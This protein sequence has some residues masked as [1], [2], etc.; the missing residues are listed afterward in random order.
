MVASKLVF[1][2]NFT[3]SL[4]LALKSLMGVGVKSMLIGYSRSNYP[5]Y[6][7]VSELALSENAVKKALKFQF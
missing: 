1:S 4:K 5:G 7:K 2:F 6:K 3:L